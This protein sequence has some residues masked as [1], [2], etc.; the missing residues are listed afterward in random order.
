[1]PPVQDSFDRRRPSP[2]SK[3]TATVKFILPP[4]MGRDIEEEREKLDPL[5]DELKQALENCTHRVI[6]EKYKYTVEVKIVH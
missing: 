1:M 4:V 6:G 3:V 2:P 5:A